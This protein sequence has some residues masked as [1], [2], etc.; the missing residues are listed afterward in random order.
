LFTKIRSPILKVGIIDPE[1]ILKGSTKNDL[2]TNT[3]NITG[4]NP[5]VYSKKAE[6]VSPSFLRFLK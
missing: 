5:A 4:K 6:R 2:I 1:G 3:I